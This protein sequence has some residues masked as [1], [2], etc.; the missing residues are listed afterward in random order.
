MTLEQGDIS[1]GIPMGSISPSSEGGGGST[2]VLPP[3]TTTTLGGIKV[4]S[5]LSIEADGTLSAT[6]GGSGGTTD[7]NALTN[8][9]QLNNIELSG[10]KSLADI[11]AQPAGDYAVTENVYTKSESDVLLGKKEDI[12]TPVAPIKMEIVTSEKAVGFNTDT[13]TSILV[14]TETSANKATTYFFTNSVYNTPYSGTFMQRLEKMGY[15]IQEFSL[16]QILKSAAAIG[17]FEG[18][19]FVPVV[20]FSAMDGDYVEPHVIS[21]FNK[22][23][24]TY[25]S[26]VPSAVISTY[27]TTPLNTA[28]VQVFDTYILT[29]HGS[30]NRV[31]KYTIDASVIS[32]ATHVLFTSFV[33]GSGGTSWSKTRLGYT[34][35]ESTY[36]H[37]RPLSIANDLDNSVSTQAVVIGIFDGVEGSDIGQN[38][39]GVPSNPVNLLTLDKSVFNQ[40][41]VEVDGQTIKIE[42]G[43]L[44]AEVDSY[45]LPPATTDALGGVKVGTGLSVTDDGTL[46]ATGGGSSYTLPPATDSV[47]GGVKVGT[48]LSVIEDGTLSTEANITADKLILTGIAKSTDNT[49]VVTSTLTF[50]ASPKIS[51]EES[52]TSVSSGISLYGDYIYRENGMIA[53]LDQIFYL[54]TSQV[55]GVGTLGKTPLNTMVQLTTLTPGL[56][57]Y[58]TYPSV[59]DTNVTVNAGTVAVV[60]KGIDYYSK[61]RSFSVVRLTETK[62]LPTLNTDHEIT[63]LLKSGIN[64]KGD[65]E[66]TDKPIHYLKTA[67]DTYNEN[68]W[69][70]IEDE[71]MWHK[72]TSTG[73]STTYSDLWPI[74][75][76]KHTAS[77]AETNYYRYEPVVNV[78]GS[79]NIR[80]IRTSMTPD[81]AK[82]TVI[83]SGA[84][85]TTADIPGSYTVAE[86]GFI[87]ARIFGNSTTEDTYVKVNNL[88]V[89]RASASTTSYAAEDSALIPVCQGDIVTYACAYG[90]DLGQTVTFI[91]YR[92]LYNSENI[93]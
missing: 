45:T 59:D 46:S 75:Y 71:N 39:A 48:G 81:Y 69:Y 21:N 22:E 16:G 61:G 29:R 31:S 93:T 66:Q 86:D 85:M 25:T 43:K 87:L 68:E 50:T 91:P 60:P 2:Y 49:K 7:Y 27:G 18:S 77:G 72:G 64:N 40:I 6:G 55:V 33:K 36:T 62:T 34:Y 90:V 37:E 76:Y 35:S 74:F 32:K 44:K 1:K 54:N 13:P 28:V 24:A 47:L 4:G 63:V 14:E 10:S 52:G 83:A 15:L 67:P 78:L 79:N 12:L 88:T 26:E 42:D 41:S 89:C 8:K 51:D 92:N 3:A 11:G 84:N 30:S 53:G 80:E 57:T 70:F 65:L 20:Y 58:G 38:T 23:D 82:A 5:N 9:P 56:Q 73:S 17:Y 19:D